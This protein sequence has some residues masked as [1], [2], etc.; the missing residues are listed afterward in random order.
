MGR[1]SP[2]FRPR[3]T[4]PARRVAARAS[5]RDAARVA[6]ATAYY[7]RAW[8]APDFDLMAALLA[9]GHVQ[10][11][12][13][14]QSVQTVGS[15]AMVNGAKHMRRIY[16]GGVAFSV[17][18]AAPAPDGAVLVHWSFSGGRKGGAVDEGAGCT[19]FEFAEDDGDG[20][21]APRIA[22]S[23]V[24]RTALRAEVEL[25]AKTTGEVPQGALLRGA[26]GGRAG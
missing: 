24:F 2:A 8:S 5:P 25:A 21:S 6:A 10:R 17:L 14:W 22:S 4:R 18:R 1:A 12:A 3:L 16:P 26:G 11:D 20:R 19:V 9:P 7:E 13:V 23:T 15:D